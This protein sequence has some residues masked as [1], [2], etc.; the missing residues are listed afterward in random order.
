MKPEGRILVASD[1]ASDA[2]LIQKLLA[3]EYEGIA[4][5]TET[6]RAVADFD[7][8]RPQ[9]LVLA[10]HGLEKA[11]QYYLGLFRH[12][13]LIHA[14][15]HRTLLLCEKDDVHR[16]YGLCRR[17][18]FD[19][20]ILF[21]PLTHDTPRLPMAVYH[22]LREL[23]ASGGDAPSP[24]EFALQAR[25]MAELEA[26]LDQ[27][28]AEGRQRVDS[29]HHSIQQAEHGIGAAL[30]TMVR[31]LAE[32]DSGALAENGARAD[33]LHDI[34]RIRAEEIAGRIG[35][36]ADAMQPV[37]QWAATIKEG[38]A[39]EL[40]SAR[41]LGSLA[42]RVRPLVLVVDDDVF[43]HHLLVEVLSGLNVELAFAVSGAQA[44][45]T[46]RRRRPDLI[47]MD[48]NLPDIDGIEATR[49]IKSVEQLAGIPVIMITG[50][51]EKHVVVDS[52]KAGAA[53]FA[54]KPLD[55]ETLVAKVGRFLA[56][57][58]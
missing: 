7:A 53:D 5:S 24:G 41:A 25:R 35:A 51:S 13:T 42:Q 12:S 21:W 40:E 32:H 16:A 44:L 8:Q 31:K 19:D 54:V 39:P 49:Q 22:A 3:D 33:L 45:A 9:V 15:P 10:F 36:I 18:Y 57:G 29:A 58:S 37:R 38:L 46:M 2:K 43:Q 27:Y 26:K 30:D 20:Y 50:K 4:L 52:L 47:L 11:E 14:H 6:E 34:H 56:R 1:V 48:V 23:A 28:V 17:D 55:R